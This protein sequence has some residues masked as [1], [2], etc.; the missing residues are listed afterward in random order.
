MYKAL[1]YF[2]TVSLFLGVALSLAYSIPPVTEH[3]E[4]NGVWA[5]DEA[6]KVFSLRRL[7]RY[8]NRQVAMTCDRIPKVCRVIGSPGRNCCR[9]RC[10]NLRTDIMNSCCRGKCVNILFNRINCGACNRRCG[11]GNNCRYGMCNYS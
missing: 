5:P 8:R 10:V 9:K 11:K 2:L 4:E 6:E 3:N 1:L 7:L